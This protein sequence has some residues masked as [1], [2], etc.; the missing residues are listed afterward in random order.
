MKFPASGW[1]SKMAG[2]GVCR[3]RRSGDGGE[4]DAAE[5]EKAMGFRF[6]FLGS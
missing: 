3:W 5:K 2:D 1:E 4:G 6:F